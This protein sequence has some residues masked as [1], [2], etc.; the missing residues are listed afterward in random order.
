M[1]AGKVPQINGTPSIRSSLTVGDL[2][3]ALTHF[4]LQTITIIVTRSELVCINKP[5]SLLKLPAQ[6]QMQV[7]LWEPFINHVDILREGVGLAMVYAP[8]FQNFVW[9]KVY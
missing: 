1:D 9:V 3:A 8:N 5:H 6:K 7:V 4:H 2:S